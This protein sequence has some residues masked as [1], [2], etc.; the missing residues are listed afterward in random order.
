M[1]MHIN[2][3]DDSSTSDK[4]LVNF[5]PVMLELYRRVCAVRATCWALPHI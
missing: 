4:N 2:A 1:Y 5:R 3:A